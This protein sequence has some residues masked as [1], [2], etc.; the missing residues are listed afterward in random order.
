MGSFTL[1]VD[2]GVRDVSEDSLFGLFGRVLAS[3]F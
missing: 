3:V 1:V 2:V